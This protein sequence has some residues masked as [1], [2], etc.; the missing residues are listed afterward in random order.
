MHVMQVSHMHPCVVAL[1]YMRM[2]V[3]QVIH[4][5]PRVVALH[6]MRTWLLVDLISSFPFEALVQGLP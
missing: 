2:H 6:Y 4:M 3:M 5:H 1:N